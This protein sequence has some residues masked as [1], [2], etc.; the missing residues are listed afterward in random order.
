MF[1]IQVWSVIDDSYITG[2][3]SQKRQRKLESNDQEFQ[4]AENLN[5]RPEVL[6][7]MSKKIKIKVNFENSD[8]VS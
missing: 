1:L 4:E 6:E 7:H 3:F 2:T 8:F 5:F